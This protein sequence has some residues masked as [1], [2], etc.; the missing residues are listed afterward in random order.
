MQKDEPLQYGKFYHIYNRGINGEK[1]FREK[2]NYE[3]FLRLY[4]KYI[5]QI[6]DTFAW[7]LV[8]NHFHLLIKI[9]EKN[10]IN[11]DTDLTGFRNLSS[12]NN[13][14]DIKNNNKPPKQF[15]SN[16][17]NAYTKAYNKRYQRHGALFERPFKRKL[18]DNEKYFKSLI[19]Y[20]NTNPVH[21]GFVD[22]PKEWKWSSY[23]S[24]ISEKSTNL[25]RDTVI[26]WFDD[27]ENFKTVHTE[28]INIINIEKWLFE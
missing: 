27:I 14:L 24:C 6:A 17:F 19:I 15:F 4:E 12:V 25:K 18:I 3:Y 28:K 11:E 26:R 8:Y 1:L 22:Y 10:E 5:E 7:C 20:I 16:L 13:I 21:H 23:L 9:K 2:T